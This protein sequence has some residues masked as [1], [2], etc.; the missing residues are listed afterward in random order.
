MCH[1]ISRLSQGQQ[2]VSSLPYLSC[3]RK[4]ESIR[5]AWNKTIDDKEEKNKKMQSFLVPGFVTLLL[6]ALVSAKAKDS[7]RMQVQQLQND[8]N[9]LQSLFVKDLAMTQANFGFDL[10]RGIASKRPGENLF[11]SPLTTSVALSMLSVGA[12]KRTKDL[13]STVLHLT[14]AKSS[15]VHS[16]FKHLIREIKEG[17][18]SAQVA[19]RIFVKKGTH[20]KEEFTNMLNKYYDARPETLLGIQDKDLYIINKW[21]ED[22]TEGNI[23]ELLKS[24]PENLSLIIL[25]AIHF[26]G[27]W[28]YK[29]DTKHTTPQPFHLNAENAS[30]VPMMFNQRYSVKLG[31]L[32]SQDQEML[33]CMILQIFFKQGKSLVVFLP[34]EIN[35]NLTALENMLTAK[36][37][38][39]QI[40]QNL[41]KTEIRLYLPKF[42]LESQQ[43][44]IPSLSELGLGELFTSADLHKISDEPLVVSAVQH[45]AA[46]EIAEEGAEASAATVVIHSRS[47]MSITEV[48]VDRPFLF[49]IRDDTNKA[50]LFIG[51]YVNPGGPIIP[52]K[53]AQLSDIHLEEFDI[54]R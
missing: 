7:S 21:V 48:R 51:R 11:M 36:L 5:S 25:S 20:L 47:G 9:I 23:K 3:D 32:H 46:I 19:S 26:K 28:K 42:K 15:N 34:N 39:D 43:D 13:L 37:V 17:D 49:L 27:E 18:D 38:N 10:Y 2:G 54:E 31:Y 24:L 30:E 35:A 45:R 14:E 53:T 4:K 1:Y 40:Q 6:T 16:T 8:E 29:F 52:V 44:L 41:M 22:K 12:G 50:V 33:N